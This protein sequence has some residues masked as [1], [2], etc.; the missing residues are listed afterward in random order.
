MTIL[1]HILTYNNKNCS[2]HW[3][4]YFPILQDSD[5][6][7]I[8]IVAMYSNHARR[9]MCRV[10]NIILQLYDSPFFLV[11]C[12]L[13]DFYLCRPTNKESFTLVICFYSLAGTQTI[14]GLVMRVRISRVLR[15]RGKE[16]SALD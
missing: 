1:L 7:R 10:C 16:S 5:S 6:Y 14:G 9:L 12:C 11:Q 8:Y 13:T 4:N 2:C 3:I 15:S